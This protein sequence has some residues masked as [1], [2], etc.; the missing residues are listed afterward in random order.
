M[1][2]AELLFSWI[3][4]LLIAGFIAGCAIDAR[5]LPPDYCS[6]D[7]KEETDINDFNPADIGLTCAQIDERL[8][9]LEEAFPM[10]DIKGKRRQATIINDIA[11][12]VAWPISLG[13]LA[14]DYSSETK[15]KIEMINQ[16]KDLLY[17]LRAF[18]KCKVVLT[19]PPRD[20]S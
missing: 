12:I 8:K 4:L 14:T 9:I 13:L 16:R 6:V 2:K 10:Q 1:E 11:G 3:K 15:A 17:R 5:D 20:G 19:I 7:A 18:K